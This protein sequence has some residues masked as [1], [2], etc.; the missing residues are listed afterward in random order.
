MVDLKP[1][2]LQLFQKGCS[3]HLI[4]MHPIHHIPDSG[5]SIQYERITEAFQEL[6]LKEDSSQSGFP[7]QFALKQWMNAKHAGVFQIFYIDT[8]KALND[9]LHLGILHCWFYGRA[10]G[11]RLGRFSGVCQNDK[12]KYKS[13]SKSQGQLQKHRQQTLSSLEISTE[14]KEM[15]YMVKRS[16]ETKTLPEKSLVKLPLPWFCSE[17]NLLAEKLEAIHIHK[18]MNT[19]GHKFFPNHTLEKLHPPSKSPASKGLSLPIKCYKLNYID[20]LNETKKTPPQP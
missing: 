12:S 7:E 10:E 19:K 5:T 8:I 9:K 20:S 17:F 15:F 14:A 4:L 18:K 2:A 16:S 6:F 3:L 11:L 1:S 13:K